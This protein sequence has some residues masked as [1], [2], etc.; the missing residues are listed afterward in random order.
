MRN[1]LP[2]SQEGRFSTKKVYQKVLSFILH[3]FCHL[4]LEQLHYDKTINNT[5]HFISQKI[6]FVVFFIINLLDNC[7][8]TKP[9]WYHYSKNSNYG[10]CF[11]NFSYDIFWWNTMA[12][13]AFVCCR[14]GECRDCVIFN[15]LRQNFQCCKSFKDYPIPVSN[16]I[17][18]S[19][20][21]CNAFIAIIWLPFDWCIC[22][23]NK[24]FRCLLRM[25]LHDVFQIFLWFCKS[26]F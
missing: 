9:L 16:I 7:F 24:G 20:K 1:S 15:D 8:L 13:L 22:Y 21:K 19:I 2:T 12:F 25:S 3:F 14:T 6:Y 11:G 4:I 10:K 26:D 18:W 5:F 23:K 17:F